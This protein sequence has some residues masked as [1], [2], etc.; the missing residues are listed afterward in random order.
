MSEIKN[1]KQ[2]ILTGS[3]RLFGQDK[4]PFDRVNYMVDNMHLNKAYVYQSKKTDIDKS[5][6]LNNFKEE[7]K[8]YRDRWVNISNLY[9]NKKILEENKKLD[10]PLSIDI[11]TASICDLACPHCSREYIVTPDKIMNFEFYKNIVDE[12]A[13]L[14]VP[15]IKLNWR[16][17]PLLNP[18]LEK[19]VKYAKQMGILEVSINTN[20]VTLTEKR[21]RKLIEAGLDVI[22]FSFDGGTKKTYEKMR[23]GRFHNNQFDQV[24]ENIK[25]FSE[26]KKEMN[27]M[28]PITKIQMILTKDT[29]NEKENF[30]S[31]FSEILDDVTVTQYNERGGS[32]N[33][34]SDEERKIIKDYYS[35]NNI[36][37]ELPYMVNI[38][39]EISISKSRKPC[40]QIYQRLMITYNGRVG[41]CC[42]DWGAQHGIGFASENAFK[43]DKTEFLKVKEKIENK[44]KGF[45]LL[46]DA[47]MPTNFNEP[48]HKVET[49]SEIWNG[50][51][52]NKVRKLHCNKKVDDVAVC[53]NCTFKDTNKKKKIN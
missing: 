4:K 36:K 37:E 26:I 43:N 1:T 7:Y 44:K 46:K 34:L 27:S 30:F 49:L 25:K 17:E 24:Y 13:S 41:M 33:D 12:A 23:P 11:E 52:L 16:G 40:E 32:I 2:E 35:K 10:P 19:F 3:A 22:I 29:K 53:K 45:E 21:S 50:K 39:G 5:Q 6:L 47:V 20:A 51:E 28:F 31:L 48:H 42:H 18:Q 38:N 9:S 15:S 14:K 8:N